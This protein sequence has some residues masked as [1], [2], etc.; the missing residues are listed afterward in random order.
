MLIDT[1]CHLEKKEYDDLDKTIE[2]IFESDTKFLIVS[3]YDLVSSEEAINL[4]H[5]Y[6]NIYASVGFHPSECNIISNK[7]YNRLEE[8]LNDSKVIAIGEIG[9]DYHYDTNNIDKQ[10]ELFERQLD[11]AE[12]FNKPVVIHNREASTDLLKILSHHKVRGVIHCFSENEYYANKF[13]ELGF[14]L[15]IGGVIT[16]KNSKLKDVIKSISIDKLVLETDSPYLSPE[17]F[18]GTK[19][20]PSKLEYIAREL[21]IVKEITY[22]EVANITS[23]NVTSLFDFNADLW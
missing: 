17:P 1:H 5:R 8:L 9:L 11:I 6:K 2:K 10:K 22:S 20:D 13:I 16:F 21:A 18:R 12:K 4:A 23:L 7:D 15:G 14:L 19:N 3:G